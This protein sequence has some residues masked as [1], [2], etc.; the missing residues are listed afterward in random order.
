M[1]EQQVA[2]QISQDVPLQA[3]AAHHM[4]QQAH[5]VCNVLQAPHLSDISQAAPGVKPKIQVRPNKINN[6]FL[7]YFSYKIVWEGYFFFFF[8]YFCLLKLRNPIFA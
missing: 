5:A 7:G 3:Q 2:P 4:P 6:M 1:Q 8:E